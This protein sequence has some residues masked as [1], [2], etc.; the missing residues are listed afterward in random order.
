MKILFVY[1]NATHQE[2]IPLGV[3]YLSAALKKAGHQTC[4]HDG[5]FISIKKLPQTVTTEQPDLIA[6]SIRSPE[7]PQARKAIAT[8]KRHT[9]IPIIVGGVHPTVA[10]IEVLN[11]EGV[12]AVCVGEGEEAFVHLCDNWGRETVYATPN[13]YFLRDGKLVKNPCLL[14]Q[15]IDDL[16]LPDRE[17]FNID[18][19]L[20]ARDGRLDIISG[21]GCPFNCTYCIN[22]VVKNIISHKTDYIRVRKP[23]NIIREIQKVAEGHEVRSLE[24]VNDIFTLSESW[25]AEFTTLYR[26]DIHLPFVCNAR[27]ELMTPKIAAL[28]K[29]AGCTEVQMG[30]ESGSERIRREVL[31]RRMSNAVIKEAF[32]TVRAAGMK[33]YAFNMVGLPEEGFAELRAS[34]ELNRHIMADAMQVS[35]FQPYPGT[36]LRELAIARG[37]ISTR[38]LPLS[39]K[40]FSIMRYPGWGAWRIRLAKLGFRFFSLLPDH[41]RRAMSAL[42]VDI[43]ADYYNMIRGIFSPKLKKYLYRFYAH[44]GK[45]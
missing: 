9:D 21:R 45:N 31:G 37:W 42:F 35:V 18:K 6:F 2:Y 15:R 16:P 10:P 28:L 8:L 34:I 43:L 20:E 11:W 22:H 40:S 14:P 13:F 32:A 3:A 27:V 7:A 36:K 26:R 1:L 19:Y 33:T 5:T 41:P 25:L 30:I 29:E 4:L 12:A 38:R 24:F 17:L 39:H 44:T 23:E